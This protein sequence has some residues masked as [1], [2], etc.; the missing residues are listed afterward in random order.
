MRKENTKPTLESFAVGDHVK[1]AK[2]MIGRLSEFG[3][4]IEHCKKGD[5]LVIREVRKEDWYVV[6]RLVDNQEREFLALPIELCE[7]K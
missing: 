3:K 2:T 6:S 4:D 7:V 5:E 1:A